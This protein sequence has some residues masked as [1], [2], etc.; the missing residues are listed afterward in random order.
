MVPLGVALSLVALGASAFLAVYV[1][2]LNPRG[3]ANRAFFVLMLAFVLWDAAEAAERVHPADAP[4]AVL[5][6]YVHAVWIGIVL[7]PSALVH[8]AL[9]YPQPSRWLRGPWAHLAIYAPFVA[10]SY[11]ILS[12]DFV[13]AGVAMGPLGPSGRV[14]DTY[15]IAVTAYSAWLYLGVSLFVIAWWRS[16]G[17]GMSR[18]Q[19]IVAT[20]LIVGSVPAGITEAFWPLL[21]GADTRLG[22]GSVYTLTWSAFIAYAVARYHYLEIEAVVESRP[23]RTVRHAL[24]RGL[25]YLVVEPGRAT[26]MGAFREIVSETPGLCVTGLARSRVVRR[27]GL[28]RTPIL[29]ITSVSSPD[30]T[31]RPSGLEFELQ[32]A[33][34]K[35][36]RENPGT[37]VLLDDLD[38]LAALNGFDAVARVVRRVTNQASASGGT[39]IL[40]VGA[41]TL[42]ADQLAVLRGSVDHVLEV[43]HG[44]GDAVPGNGDHVL[45]VASPEEAADALAGAGARGGLLFTMEHPAKARRRFGPAYELVWISE[46]GDA[47]ATRVA[48]TSLDAEAKRAL[49]HYVA[50]HTGSDVVL[51]ALEQL[52]L[53]HEFRSLLAFVKDAMDLASA[54]GCRLFVTVGPDSLA[55]ADLAMLRRRFDVPTTDVR[56]AAPPGAPTTAVPESRILYRGPVS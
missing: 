34:T 36:L 52:A 17:N 56:R 7:V 24:E 25:N 18:M 5:L 38:Y 48:P 1:L 26:A 2:G 45:V 33:V 31:V 21:A 3:S 44:G 54:G 37:A 32:H 29:A 43:L 6:P 13:I 46:G 49:V 51:V 10:W 39:A 14:S 41:G 27:F 16:R 35:F 8:L 9:A 20:G 53:Y 50:G 11:A 40:A 55:P 30:L 19:A 42:P 12:T 15:P 47:D 28:E 22:L 4:E 23:P